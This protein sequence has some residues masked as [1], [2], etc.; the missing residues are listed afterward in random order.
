MIDFSNPY[1]CKS[2]MNKKVS[3]RCDLMRHIKACDSHIKTFNDYY[4]KY[5]LYGDMTCSSCTNN[6][7]I[8]KTKISISCRSCR[9]SNVKDAIKEAR[10]H[11]MD[12]DPD[13]VSN[14]QAKRRATTLSKYGTEHISQLTSTKEKVK[15]TNVQRYGVTH[16]LNNKQVKDARILA[17]NENKDA[18]NQKRKDAWTDELITK[19][20]LNRT[21][22]L[23]RRYGVD[24]SSQIPSTSTKISEAALLRYRDPLFLKKCKQILTSY[25][26]VDN[27]SK[28]D[29]VKSRVRSTMELDG[30]WIELKFIADFQRYR[31]LCI[32]ETNKHKSILF[33]S[34]NGN[35]YYENIALLTDTSLSNEPLYRTIDHKTSIFHGFV[36]GILPLVIG[37]IN[38]LCICSRSVNSRK[39]KRT[40]EEF[41]NA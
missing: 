36:Y 23:N 33:N 6:K 18:I 41:I 20:K 5:H 2:C 27:V 22:T 7:E 4:I 29:W 32:I 35:C 19:V 28:L 16:T 30:H 1:T 31:R 40:V 10:Q 3:R 9:L 11:K 39:G 13:Y 25:Y 8:L 24:Y 38:N 26:G 14:I 37:D 17:L 15:Y 34:W 21:H 12:N